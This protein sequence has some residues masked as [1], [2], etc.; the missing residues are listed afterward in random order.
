MSRSPSLKI[1]PRKVLR[2]QTPFATQDGL[3]TKLFLRADFDPESH[4]IYA[5]DEVDGDSP[6]ADS[7]AQ[8]ESGGREHYEEVAASRLR[9]PVQPALGQRYASSRISREALLSGNGVRG[10]KDTGDIEGKVDS[11]EEDPFAPVSEESEEDPFA[12][13]TSIGS[14]NEY[15]LSDGSHSEGRKKMKAV[16]GSLP[17]EEDEEIDSDDAFGEDDALKFRGFKFLGSRRMRDRMEM[18]MNSEDR[19]G[20][21]ISSSSGSL[22]EVQRANGAENAA[23]EEDSEANS[24]LSDYDSDEDV[25]VD[26]DSEASSELPDTSPPSL[27]APGSSA[28][29]GDRA[30]LKALLSSDTAAV[31][32]SLSAAASADAKKGR[33]VR[34]QYQTFDRLLDA[35]IKMQK[36]LTAA[37]SI[38]DEQ[39]LSEHKDAIKAAEEAALSLW[40]TITSIRHS[41]AEAQS[42]TPSAAP[43]N[44]K[45]RKRPTPATPSTAIS[46]LWSSTRTLNSTTGPHHRT[47]LNKWSAK[48]R[49]S[50]PTARESTSR[51]L[52]LTT[53]NK[54]AN[55]STTQPSITDLIDSHLATEKLLAQPSNPSSSSSTTHPA[56]DD[57]GFYQSL[58]R[59]LITSRSSSINN[60]NPSPLLPR[61]TTDTHTQGPL[62]PPGSAHK[63]SRI[64][65]K[66]SKGRKVRYT[67]HEKLQNFMPAEGFGRGLD[68]GSGGSGTGMGMGWSEE[69]RREFFASLFGGSAVLR[70]DDED[71]E[72]DD[73]EGEEGGQALR[74]FRS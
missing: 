10:S 34:A 61:N 36:G 73:G 38:T 58:L 44:K 40:N 29:N 45:K 70:E 49:A 14:E 16:S 32:S 65:T 17:E 20:T 15:A 66:A 33:A 51:L 57:S 62:H 6:C 3:L 41:Y 55:A 30:A 28:A 23:S 4:D 59:D 27:K 53:N 13:G 5:N 21:D 74:L 60:P 46:T 72:D 64:D 54:N 12:Q 56:Y 50:N 31:A 52:P 47:I 26:V 67:V 63:R 1:Q 71:E 42:Q 39:D 18:G 11:A 37:N 68:G 19:N 9:R 35:R 69:A 22:N 24:Q 2:S 43:E 48:V 25:D 7:R 8:G